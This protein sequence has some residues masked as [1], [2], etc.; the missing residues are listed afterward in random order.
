MQENHRAAKVPTN[1]KEDIKPF[2]YNEQGR[3]TRC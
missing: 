3:Q 2:T 1:L